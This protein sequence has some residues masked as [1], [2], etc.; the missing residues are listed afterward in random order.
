MGIA[1]AGEEGQK[2]LRE[3]GVKDSKKLRKTKRKFIYDKIINGEASLSYVSYNQQDSK[4]IDRTNLNKLEVQM[5]LSL[6]HPISHIK[7]IKFL[8]DDFTNGSW[9]R[10]NFPN[11][12]RFEIKADENNIVVAA[13]SVIAKVKRD[14]VMKRILD[15][16]GFNQCSGYPADEKTVNLLTRYYEEHKKFPPFTRTRWELCKRI[17]KILEEKNA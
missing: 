3:L 5:C 9:K 16:G 17:V 7:D 15:K 4:I 6:M 13:A 8:V 1:V 2:K 11:N 12:V 10:M 14:E